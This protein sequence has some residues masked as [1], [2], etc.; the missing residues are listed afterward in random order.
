MRCI[1]REEIGSM[2]FENGNNSG[3]SESLVL[4]ENQQL[5][6]QHQESGSRKN[7]RWN[8]HPSCSYEM[9]ALWSTG[10]SGGLCSCTIFPPTFQR[11]AFHPALCIVILN[12]FCVS[13]T[14]TLI[15]SPWHF[16]IYLNFCCLRKQNKLKS[17]QPKTTERNWTEWKE[18]EEK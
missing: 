5:K 15:F 17:R 8:F 4:N 13:K 6:P 2:K 12:P 7:I 1:E 16:I 9:D 10:A 18:V 11:F 3:Q 14:M